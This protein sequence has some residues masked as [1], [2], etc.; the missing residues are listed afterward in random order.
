[1]NKLNLRR[2]ARI[3]SLLMVSGITLFSCKKESTPADTNQP[4]SSGNVI[5]V[6]DSLTGDVHW[7]ADNV[8][9]LKGWVYAVDGT[10][11]TI[12]PGTIIKGDK[13]T[14]AALIIEPGAKIM[15]QGTEMKPIVFTS[16]Q[17]VGGRS[18]GDW[19]GVILCGKA[20][21]NSVV[22]GVYPIV[23]GGP[24]TRYG[25]TDPADNTGVF[26]YVRIEYG[27]IAFSP[28]N[29]VNG[30]TLAG[31][32]NGTKLDHVMVSFSGDDSYEFFGGTVNADH[33]VAL[34]GWDDD[35]D[36][37]NGYSGN[38]QFIVGLRDPYAAD[39]SGS[40]GFESDN[41]GAGSSNLPQTSAVFSNATIIG[42]LV[43]P[44]STAYS[45]NFVSGAHIRRN[46]SISIFNT[47][48]MGWPAGVLIDDKPAGSTSGNVN[49][50]KCKF[51]NN[52]VSGIPTGPITGSD[53]KNVVYVIN[54]AGSLTSTAKMDDSTGYWAKY[55]GPITWFNTASF[56]N[57]IYAT[58]GEVR[59]Q[60]PFNLTNPNFIPTTT[61]PIIDSKVN[62]S[63]SGKPV[64]AADF[65]DS[66][67]SNAFF[68]KVGYIGAFAGT[69][70]TSD[71]WLANWTNFDPLH[72]AY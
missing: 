17:P 13:D 64:I 16:N 25:G 49:S 5:T 38:V 20:P 53:Q 1:M 40:K 54:G 4:S 34:A 36:T 60:N 51:I 30:L 45:S 14:K 29:E 55:M 58:P 12:D 42:G 22:N 48:I 18:Y 68:Q 24:R 11:L 47:V 37:D 35:F 70:S 9:F 72:T 10:T 23:E 19:G 2:G 32:G 7:T 50:D 28:D 6:Q 27:G 63:W 46:S 62:G 57:K 67:L 59:L 65:S 31:V 33:L 66:K 71:N 39:A 26:S 15:A 69:Q 52:I 56:N 41:D 21:V 61:S 44:N 8:Y 43:D 3:A